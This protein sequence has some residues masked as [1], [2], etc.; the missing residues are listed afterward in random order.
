MIVG[1]EP[2]PRVTVKTAAKVLEYAHNLSAPVLPSR[3]RMLA[4]IVQF[5]DCIVSHVVY[6]RPNKGRLT[7]LT[8]IV[9]AGEDD[10]TEIVKCVRIEE[11]EWLS[12][13]YC[14]AAAL[15]IGG[16]AR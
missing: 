3:K 15:C 2:R 7:V 13:G 16:V 8:G 1:Q 12:D 6:A 10:V 11:R 14:T 9:I 5:G 4:L